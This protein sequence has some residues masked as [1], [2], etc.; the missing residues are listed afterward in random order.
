MDKKSAEL[1]QQMQKRIQN[2]KNTP[3]I[4]DAVGQYGYTNERLDQGAALAAEANRL[5]ALKQKE[6][7]DKCKAT[8]EANIQFASMNKEYVKH[9]E[10]AR[11]ALPKDASAFTALQFGGSRETATSACLAQVASFYTNLLGNPVWMDAIAHF[12]IN[13]QQL[14][15]AQSLHHQ[16]ELA[17]SAQLKD[18][19][20]AHGATKM[21]NEVVRTAHAWDSQYVKVA[22]IALDGQPH[23]LE[24]LGIRP[25]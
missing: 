10:L 18:M 7:G 22:R 3:E 20:E 19:G 4:M 15:K 6:Y 9:L 11:I 8:D 23:L 2:S 17:Y 25:R 5:D 1:I 21:R 14:E 16:V 24:I 12:G 13:R